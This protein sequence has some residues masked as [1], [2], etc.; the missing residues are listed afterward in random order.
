MGEPK[1]EIKMDEVKEK[2]LKSSSW[3]VHNKRQTNALLPLVGMPKISPSWTSKEKLS[4]QTASTQIKSDKATFKGLSC[5]SKSQ[6]VIG[7]L[8]VKPLA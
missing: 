5:I 3:G 4:L 7:W 6:R 2:Q 1:K 8:N